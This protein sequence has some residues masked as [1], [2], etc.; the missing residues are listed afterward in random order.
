MRHAWAEENKEYRRQYRRDQYEL[1]REQEL[2]QAREWKRQNKARCQAL[3]AKRIAAKIRATPPWADQEK[4]TAFYAEAIRLSEETGIKYHVDHI[5]P[6]Q[7]K[8]VCGLRVHTNLQV[9]PGSENQ[10]KSNR[11][12]PDMFTL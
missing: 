6:L 9:I 11:Y 1:K 8:W 5:V 10:A 12:W 3:V 4:I 7:S 2:A